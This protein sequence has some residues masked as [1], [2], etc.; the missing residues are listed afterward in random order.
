MPPPE[1]YF[2]EVE[3]RSKLRMRVRVKR[4]GGGYTVGQTGI[5]HETGYDPE[6]AGYYVVV[7][8]DNGDPATQYTRTAYEANV[9]ELA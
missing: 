1:H 9:E 3:A 5:V 6:T 8:W 4:G 2:T 7:Y